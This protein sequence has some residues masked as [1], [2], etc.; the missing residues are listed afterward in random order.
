MT[1][2]QVSR[3]Q[4]VKTAV[5]AAL[6]SASWATGMTALRRSF[7]QRPS[8][9]VLIYYKFNTRAGNTLTTPPDV[10]HCQL[11]FLQRHYSLVTPETVLRTI[12]DGAPFPNRAVLLTFDDGYRDVYDVAYPMLKSRGLRAAL[13][14]ATDYIGTGRL[15]PHDERLPVSNPTLDWSHLREMQDVFAIGS[16]TMSHRRLTRLSRAEA[17][18]EIVG[19]KK[20]LED[21]LGRQ[22]RMF[23]YPKGA[24]E[25]ISLPL[26]QMVRDAGYVASFVTLTGPNSLSR[27]RSGAW[28][29]RFHA[30]PFTGFLFARLL[31][32]SCDAIGLKD[33]QWGCAAKHAFN[34]LLRTVTR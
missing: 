29:R 32:G 26:E 27:V 18:E 2:T 16:H 20:L 22:V 7:E 1:A 25:D 28:L 34:H 3:K 9:R 33:T 21:R 6:G 10:F 14:P 8:L 13:F 24:A 30:E 11:D 4:R 17:Q 12:A 31:D 23:C 15:F 19:S 5:Y